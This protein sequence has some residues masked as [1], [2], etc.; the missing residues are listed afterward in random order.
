MR[1]PSRNTSGPTQ[2]QRDDYQYAA[3][4]FAAWLPKLRTLVQEDLEALV[5]KLEKIDA[6]W[7]P[8]RFPKWEIE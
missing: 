1:G 2:T 3:E 4:A 7:T 5:E 6:P 8:G